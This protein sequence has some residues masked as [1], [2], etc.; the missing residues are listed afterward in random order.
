MHTVEERDHA[1]QRPRKKMI[2]AAT[3]QLSGSSGEK[4]L[5]PG[6]AEPPKHSRTFQALALTSSTA[7]LATSSTGGHHLLS[8][9]CGLSAFLSVDGVVVVVVVG[10]LQ[11]LRTRHVA[12]ATMTSRTREGVCGGGEKSSSAAPSAG[13]Q[14]VMRSPS[15]ALAAEEKT[16]EAAERTPVPAPTSIPALA[17]AATTLSRH[18]VR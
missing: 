13:P 18:S 8:F 1:N 17:I 6:S 16:V 11:R 2:A 9:S 5:A 3:D 7:S 12:A 4:N 15:A 14:Q 10:G